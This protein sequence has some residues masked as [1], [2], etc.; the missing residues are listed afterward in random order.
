MDVIEMSSKE[1]AF[2]SHYEHKMSKQTKESST[3]LS[4]YLISSNRL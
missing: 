4:L 2:L 1:N 3:S